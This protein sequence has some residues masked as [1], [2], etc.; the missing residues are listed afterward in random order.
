MSVNDMSWKV[1]I[2]TVISG[3]L[4]AAMLGV[5][6]THEKANAVSI[7]QSHIIK[8][9]LLNDEELKNIDAELEI[10]KRQQHRI[11]ATILISLAEMKKDIQYIK[12]K[13]K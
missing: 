7:N 2:T 4:L 3:L 13:T 8:E 12:E 5:W 10:I 1:V 9:L 6:A 11:E